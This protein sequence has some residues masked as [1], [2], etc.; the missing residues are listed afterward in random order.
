MYNY[1]KGRVE[2]ISEGFVVLESSGIGYNINAT[3][4]TISRLSLGEE[5]KLHVK[6]IVREDEMSIY[7]FGTRDEKEMFELLIGVSSIG[8]R[9]AINILSFPESGSIAG[10][11]MNA[12]IRSLSKFPGVGKKTAERIVLELRDKLSKRGWTEQE[13][14]L[15]EIPEHSELDEAV[16]ALAALGYSESE[17]RAAAAKAAET[18]QGTQELIKLSFKYLAR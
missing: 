10:Y 17:A 15:S 14:A 5:I 9:S 18:A 16:Q 6:L 12:D 3:F 8:P 11:I 13:C 1:I 2:D 7:G 4:G